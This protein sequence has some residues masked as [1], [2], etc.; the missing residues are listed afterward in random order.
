MCTPCS[1]R[2]AGAGGACAGRRRERDGAG[3]ARPH[4]PGS[5]G[6]AR[7]SARGG[8]R[9]AAPGLPSG[10]P[11]P[12][13]VSRVAEGEASGRR[14]HLLAGVPGLRLTPRLSLRRDTERRARA[15][16][17]P[18]LAHPRAR[19]SA[20]RRRLGTGGRPPALALRRLFPP[21]G[22]DA[23]VTSERQTASGR[24]RRGRKVPLMFGSARTQRQS[25]DSPCAGQR[26][27]PAA[28]P[29][30]PSRAS[31]APPHSSRRAAAC[32]GAT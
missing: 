10:G 28:P 20:S 2:T 13:R 30:R 19:S 29:R 16:Q 14:A 26:R 23:L 12:G 7:P 22:P 15:P 31:Q 11:R 1:T 21:P 25:A 5:P 32:G 17:A 18:S 6:P 24:H 4:P 3:R 8:G 27:P 9:R